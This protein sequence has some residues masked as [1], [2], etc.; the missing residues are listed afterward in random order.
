MEETLRLEDLVQILKK[1]AAWIVLTTVAGIG[2]AAGVTFFLITPKY[3]ST[4]QLIAQNQEAEGSSGNLQNDINGNVLM[5]N[6]YKD[7]IKID[8]VIDAVQ[9][10]LQDEYQYVYSNSGLKNSL[11]VEQAQNLQMFQITATSSEPRKAALI[12]NITAITFQEK[13]EEVLAVSKVTITSEAGV[14]AKAVFP[15]NQLNLLIGTVVG[16]LIGVGLAFLIELVDKT[17]KDER[18]IVETLELPVLGQVSEINPKQLI[19][20]RRIVVTTREDNKPTWEPQRSTRKRRR[21]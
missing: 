8:L 18:F 15:N 11:E 16:M 20:S 3:D 19:R 1:K 14:S 6:T 12:A 4:A 10:K 21:I 7:M 2:L 17:M 13:A 9:K 5:I